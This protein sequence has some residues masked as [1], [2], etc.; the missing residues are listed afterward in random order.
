[1]PLQRMQDGFHKSPPVLSRG[2]EATARRVLFCKLHVQLR[3]L[4]AIRRIAM[5]DWPTWQA[6]Y[7]YAF[8]DWL[9]TLTWRNS[10]PSRIETRF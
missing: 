6:G 9:G 1:M 5:T 2:T 8:S 3:R 10:A 4:V 7:I